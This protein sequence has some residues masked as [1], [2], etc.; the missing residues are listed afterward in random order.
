MALILLMISACTDNYEELNTRH[1]LV[2]E[3]VLDTDLL[4]TYVLHTKWIYYGETG[5]GTTGNYPG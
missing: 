2:T 4:L 5:G 1:D 3:D